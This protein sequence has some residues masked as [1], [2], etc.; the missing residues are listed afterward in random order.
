MKN[1][2]ITVSREFGSGGRT[3]G[4]ETA[5]KL[6][7]PCYDWEIID[8]VAEK[9]GFS[10]EYIEQHGEYSAHRTWIGRS[11]SAGAM[12]GFL[13]NQD[14]IWLIQRKVILEL[15]QQGPCVIVGRCAD[16]ILKDRAELL[17]V[18]IHADPKARAE[19]IVK[20]YGETDQSPE[21]RL[22]DKDKRRT[23]YYRFYTETEWGVA[24][25]YHISLDSGKIGI[26]KCVEIIASLYQAMEP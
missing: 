1:K 7:I 9:S 20:L 13:S 12:G 24:K 15:A 4:K 14:N 16:Y 22:A 11:L 21:K 17:K 8:K 3:I 5:Q 18:F 23:A 2:I 25:N 26:D 10:K 19:R 6:G